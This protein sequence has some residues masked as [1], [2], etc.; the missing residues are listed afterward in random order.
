MPSI[1]HLGGYG[2]VIHE[3]TEMATLCWGQWEMN[4]R[5]SRD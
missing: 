4:V 3:Q 5:D 2:H 1:Y